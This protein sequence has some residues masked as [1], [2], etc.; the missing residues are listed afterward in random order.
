MDALDPY[1]LL[2]VT[3]YAAAGDVRRAY[4]QLALLAHP[5]KGGSAAD[6]A[7]VSAAYRY[8][9]ARAP[10]EPLAPTPELAAR[11][12]RAAEEF[13]A[14]LESQSAE[15]M[16]P[17]HEILANAFGL[18]EARYV[19]EFLRPALAAAAGPSAARA[20]PPADDEAYARIAYQTVVSRAHALLETAA[21]PVPDPMRVIADLTAEF[22]A[23]RPARASDVFPAAIAGGYGAAMAGDDA[24]DGGPPPLPERQIVARATPSAFAPPVASVAAPPVKLPRELADYTVHATPTALADYRLAHAPPERERAAAE[25]L[26]ATPMAIAEFASAYERRLADRLAEDLQNSAGIIE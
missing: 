9:I 11:A 25:A 16:L 15:R 10:P 8:A 2:G 23:A 17:L 20:A 1:G 12:A 21:T 13:R 7:T 4:Y 6:M 26:P 22:V 24:P 18:N 5:D 14:F 19:A 3:P